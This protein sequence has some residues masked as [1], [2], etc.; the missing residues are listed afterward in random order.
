MTSNETKTIKILSLRIYKR[1]VQE[2]KYK[3]IALEPNMFNSDLIVWVFEDNDEIQEIL[4]E[5][6]E[7]KNGGM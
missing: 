4:R 6:R 3:P 2:T 7:K 5:E 1:I